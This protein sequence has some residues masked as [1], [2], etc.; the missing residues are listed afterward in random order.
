MVVFTKI[1]LSNFNSLK[2]IEYNIC[3]KQNTTIIIL[4]ASNLSAKLVKLKNSSNNAKK[5]I[6]CTILKKNR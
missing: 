3:I 6:K 2:K 4:I 1:I 5:L